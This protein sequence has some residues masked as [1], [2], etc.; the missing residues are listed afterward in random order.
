MPRSASRF[1]PGLL[2]VSTMVG[3]AGCDGGD[4]SPP[5]NL[6]SVSVQLNWVPEPEF[7]GFWQ[8]ELDGVFADAGLD[9]ALIAGG[10]SVPSAQLIASGKVPF[11]V[12]SGGEMLSINERGGSLVA[13]FATFQGDPTAIMVHESSPWK[14]LEEL[15]RS[16]A[17]VACE[18]NLPFVTFLN[19]KY[20]GEN[21]KLVAHSTALANFVNDPTLAKQCFVFAE[22]VTLEL[23]NVPV[24]VFPV[25]ESG[26]N[27]YTAV[28]VTTREHLA[29]N[30]ETCRAM[31][32]ALR[33]GW[34]GY[35]ADPTKANEA[36]A[37]LNPAMSV[38]AMNLA[39]KK[40]RFLVEDETTRSHA[41][42]WMTGERWNTLAEQMNSLGK[43]E[44]IPDEIEA[45][46]WQPPVDDGPMAPALEDSATS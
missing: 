23:E 9:V 27:P 14:T 37:K 16:D 19:R 7:G 28:V 32:M 44:Q 12:V 43:L 41:V 39:A 4:P 21:L 25:L 5:S 30:P 42:G 38:E 3:L 20:G 46:F 40:Q 2:I 35:L 31:V 15:W 17:T 6:T 26:F 45:I 8:A 11:G 29:A 13:L 22:P 24:R 18:A 36:M 10:P 33:R 1:I 34:D